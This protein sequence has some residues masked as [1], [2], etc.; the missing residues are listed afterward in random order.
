MSSSSPTLFQSTRPRSSSRARPP[1]DL[2]AGCFPDDAKVA[3]GRRSG[4]GSYSAA[5][6]AGR[7]FTLDSA[8]STRCWRPTP[9]LSAAAAGRIW[10]GGGARAARRQAVAGACGDGAAG[11]AGACSSG[12]RATS[13]CGWWRRPPRHKAG[14]VGGGLAVAAVH[15]SHGLVRRTPLSFCD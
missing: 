1:P 6:V 15:P 10:E 8:A 7:S 12:A 13:S 3:A 9:P 2:A 14:R 11:G 5:S 4:G